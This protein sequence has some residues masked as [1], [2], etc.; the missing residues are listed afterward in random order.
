MYK[1]RSYIPIDLPRIVEIER[2]SF[3]IAWTHEEFSDYLAQDKV[4]CKVVLLNE[5][6]VGYCIFCVEE[7][8]FF[9]D[10]IAIDKLHR[11]KK[12]A[13][14]LIESV[15]MTSKGP[16]RLELRVRDSNFQACKF[17]T[18]LGFICSAVDKNYYDDCPDDSYIFVL[19]TEKKR[20]LD[21]SNRMTKNAIPEQE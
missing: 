2:E 8:G 9:I 7:N 17:F 1:Y 12:L 20:K 19:S 6:V 16:R 3:P 11:R 4:K 18:K 21:F 15:R 10:N 14:K 5:V 13:T